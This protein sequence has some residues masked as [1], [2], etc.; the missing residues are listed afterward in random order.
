MKKQNKQKK[1]M[2]SKVVACALATSV[3]LSSLPATVLAEQMVVESE[4][5]GQT[6][7]QQVK[8]PIAA[9]S[10]GQVVEML[11]KAADRYTP[12][13]T[14]N[15]IVKGYEDGNAKEGQDITKVEALAMISRAFGTLPTP[16]GNDERIKPKN[17]TFTDVP[18]WAEKDIQNL[19]HAGVLEGTADG[20]LKGTEKISLKEVETVVRRIW[21]LKG[22]NPKDDFYSN[23]NKN[24]LDN[25]KLAPGEMETGGL[26]GLR[27]IV[28]K[29][30]QELIQEIVKGSGYEKGSSEEKIQKM[31]KSASDMEARN[32]LGIEP[33]RKYLEAINNSKSIEELD[34]AQNL[35]EKELAMRGLFNMILMTDYQDS[36]KKA[37]YLHSPIMANYTKE[38]YQDPNHERINATRTL[39][40]K[41]L[42]L[43][44]E[45]EEEAKQHVNDLL[46]LEEQ[47]VS[48]KPSE[49]ED[50]QQK[51][52]TF[53]ELQKMLPAIDLQA[54][55]TSF[56]F[57]VPKNVV[58]MHPKVFEE[59]TKLLTVKNLPVLKALLK[60]NLMEE[61]RNNLGQDLIDVYNE[62]YKAT[63]GMENSTD[64]E[65]QATKLVVENLADYI[66]KLYAEKYFSEEAKQDVEEM[67]KGLIES[68]KERIKNLDW[69]SEPTKK[70]ANAKL[71]NMTFLIGAPEF[72]DTHKNTEITDNFFENVMANMKI[73]QSQEVQKQNKVDQPVT[74]GMASFTVNAY[75]NQH[76]NVMAFP[77]AILQAPFYDVNA[78]TE[79]NLAGI[80]AIIAHEITHAFDNNGAKYDKNGNETDWWDPKDYAKFKELCDQ[81]VNFYEGWESA[82]GVAM[83]GKQTL[84][85]NIA[86]IGGVASALDLLKKKGNADYDKFF[87]HYAKVWARATTRENMEN[88]AGGDEHSFGKLRVNRVLVNFEEFYKT[89]NIEKGD[90]MYVAPE[91]RIIIW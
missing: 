48:F 58:I 77:A 87:R 37:L 1:P 56:G 44:G 26:G 3:I 30:V 19:I 34:I 68:F 49:E 45:S 76:D 64:I 47:M 24:F 71:D 82:T 70:E 65:E 31:F 39:Y 2:K 14:K 40:T 13:L 41:L 57:E 8:P 7:G 63:T 91:D 88:L 29:Q 21:S 16:V 38:E 20:S 62:Y 28:D 67:I 11:M 80:G 66:G 74:M 42:V 52:I 33:L 36:K 72:E 27:N 85:E 89:Y 23:V 86:D 17:V 78:S 10:R 83:N 6:T 60:I 46:K 53:E 9:V 54:Y 5:P 69:M 4:L 75:Y 84:G 43:S 51:S 90:G 79:E 12:G 35:M 25:S 55:F 18:K 50:E 32:K 59:F 81:T 15:M 22:S 61:N 73:I